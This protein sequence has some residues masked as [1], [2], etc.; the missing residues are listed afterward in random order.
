MVDWL[1]GLDFGI[2]GHLAF[3]DVGIDP[4]LCQLIKVNR[5]TTREES[6]ALPAPFRVDGRT[7]MRSMTHLFHCVPG[8]KGL[9]LAAANSNG[10]I[11]VA[12]AFV[13]PSCGVSKR[14]N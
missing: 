2:S 10:P 1:L 12:V 6:T 5:E 3:G 11:G 7:K 8:Q 13:G 4:H 14:L 9:S